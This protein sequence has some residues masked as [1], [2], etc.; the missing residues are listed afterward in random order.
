M[1]KI[2]N[3][4]EYYIVNLS[5]NSHSMCQAFMQI[6]RACWKLWCVNKS[7]AFLN[8]GVLYIYCCVFH[9]SSWKQ[10]NVLSAGFLSSPWKRIY[11]QVSTQTHMF[12]LAYCRRPLTWYQLSS[13]ITTW[14]KFTSAW[15]IKPKQTPCK[16]N[17]R[18]QF[19]EFSPDVQGEGFRSEVALENWDE[20]ALVV[21]LKMSEEVFERNSR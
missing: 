17:N 13:L 3:N 19:S 8:S 14:V 1:F 15:Q 21:F 2:L 4:K 9:K 20:A 11:S 16:T 7:L 12:V 6:T 18:I 5:E 10:D